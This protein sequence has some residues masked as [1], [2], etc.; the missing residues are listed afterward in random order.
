MAAGHICITNLFF[1]NFIKILSSLWNC[2]QLD[3]NSGCLDT[4]KPGVYWF[5]L[6]HVM[7]AVASSIQYRLFSMQ[8]HETILSVKMDFEISSVSDTI[9]PC[10]K[11]WLKLMLM[12]WIMY[13]T[14]AWQVTISIC[15]RCKTYCI[16]NCCCDVEVTTLALYSE[17]PRS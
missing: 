7:I 2:C 8:L 17:F 1:N 15:L 10:R 11:L 12:S 9:L 14:Y 4:R 13:T 3:G 16:K 6:C 5:C